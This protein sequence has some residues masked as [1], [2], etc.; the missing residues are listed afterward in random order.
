VAPLAIQ[1]CALADAPP[2]EDALLGAVAPWLQAATTTTIQ[3]NLMLRK[4][5]RTFMAGCFEVW[6]FCVCAKRFLVIALP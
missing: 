4:P 5:G 6:R 3:A 2:K 1:P